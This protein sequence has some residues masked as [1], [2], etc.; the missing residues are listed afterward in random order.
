MAR[1]ADGLEQ[2]WVR[3]LDS[4]TSRPLP[5]T[6]RASYPF[7]SPDS[8]TIGFFA[9]GKLKKIDADG[10]PPV[11]VCD[12]PTGRGGTWNAQ[13][14]ILFAPTETDSLHRV[15]AAG[16]R[17][18]PVTTVDKTAQEDTH[19]WPFFLPDGRHF[20]YLLRFNG[21]TQQEPAS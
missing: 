16:G 5:G 17:S 4:L 19:R 14:D 18:T 15:S 11:S 2:L 8:R 7:W 13:G 3:P 1:D 20:L 12:A 10:G 9:N 21:V 6:E